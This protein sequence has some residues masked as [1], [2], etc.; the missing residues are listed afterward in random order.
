VEPSARNVISGVGR[1]AIVVT[2]ADSSGSVIGNL[3][4]TDVT[5]T[6][7][8]GDAVGVDVVD[9][10][11]L[12]RG[13]VIAGQ[14]NAGIKLEGSSSVVQGNF[15]GTDETA[16]LPLG[17]PG[18]GIYALEENGNIAIGGTA[19]GEANVIAHNGRTFFSMIG[20]VH[21]RSPNVTIRA[22]RIFDNLYLGIDLL[23]GRSGGAVT[24]N[25]PG[26][27]DGGPNE[28][29]NFPIITNV[30]QTP[31]ATL[32][33]GYLDSTPSTAFDVDLFF[34]PS[35]NFRPWGFAQGEQYVGAIAVTTDGAGMATFSTSVPVEIQ[36]GQSVTATATDPQGRTS[37]FSQRIILSIEPK[38]GPAEGG[39]VAT[40][41]GMDFGPGTVVHVA[42][43]PVTN[44]QIVDYGTLTGTMPALPAGVVYDVVAQNPPNGGYSLEKSWL[45]DFL[46]VP[47]SHPFHD[48]VVRLVTNG[49]S[50]GV[51]GGNFGIG[52]AAA[53]QQMAVFLMK[54]KRGICYAPPPC[55]GVFA[56]VP[57]TSPFA[58][59]IEALA[60]EGITGG[61]GGGNFCPGSPVRRDQM[62]VFLLK[63]L[64]GPDF[65]PQ[66]CI[67]VFADVPCPSLFADWIEALAEADITGG[68]GP[69]IYC[70]TQS[71][72]RGQMAVFVG[73]TFSLF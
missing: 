62:A 26:D 66:P 16:T 10:S 20:G 64:A 27:T 49:V 23:N 14:G 31:G 7:A 5:G 47:E 19:A 15:I 34:G 51:G 41:F 56:D 46:D 71:V 65:V 39:T 50:A 55:A 18:G 11:P 38:S 6:Q 67:G 53:R 21:V 48:Y 29:Q 72:T 42:G 30:S 60:A 52:T 4:G 12:I 1:N 73:K 25:D 59:W 70:P 69:G 40:I 9:A 35:C 24:P 13:N 54:A 32:I 58:P 37:E 43:L 2:N 57:C 36:P 22:N 45:S 33:Q 8:I 61:C 28:S 63:A 44:I 68:C 3:I 17:N